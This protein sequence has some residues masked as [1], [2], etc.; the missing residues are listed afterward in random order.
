MDGE[1][2]EEAGGGAGEGGHHQ[3]R[4]HGGAARG[5]QGGQPSPQEGEQGVEGG[6]G[7][8]EAEGDEG[9][10]YH[11]GLPR[12]GRGGQVQGPFQTR[13]GQAGEPGGGVLQAGA[14]HLGLPGALPGGGGMPQD[15]QL[16]AHLG[17]QPQEGP[18]GG[19]GGPQRRHAVRQEA[20]RGVLREH[21]RL[22]L[23]PADQAEEQGAAPGEAGEEGEAAGEVLC[24]PERPHHHP[25]DQAPPHRARPAQGEGALGGGEGRGGPAEA[26]PPGL[27]PPHRPQAGG[28]GEEAQGG[29][30]HRTVARQWSEVTWRPVD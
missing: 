15:A 12:Q 28:A 5:G 18:R 3:A 19:V 8:D 27:L 20:G 1:R 23:L 9:Q 4:L 2:G 10:H 29:P 21:R 22:P 17:H 16:G 6:G 30:A 7:R 14:G 24:E 13:W 26:P 11:Q 25:E